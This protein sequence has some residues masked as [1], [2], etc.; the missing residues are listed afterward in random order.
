MSG[1]NLEPFAPLSDEQWSFLSTETLDKWLQRRP[2][3]P[4][5]CAKCVQSNQRPRI[6]FDDDGVCSACRYWEKRILWTGSLASN[7]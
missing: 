7:N 4:R 1:N 5:F 2:E 6:Q 3:D